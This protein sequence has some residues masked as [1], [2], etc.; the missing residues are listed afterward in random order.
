LFADKPLKGG[1]PS[2]IL[3]EQIGDLDVLV[4]GADCRSRQGPSQFIRT[5]N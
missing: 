4:A 3:L 1:D 2:L 5:R